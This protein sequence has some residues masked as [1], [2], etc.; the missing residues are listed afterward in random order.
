MFDSVTKTGIMERSSA[1]P[2]N[3]KGKCNDISIYRI[4]TNFMGKQLINKI[5][6]TRLTYKILAFYGTRK[7]IHTWS[8]NKVRELATLCL[9]WQQWTKTSVWFD[10]V[11]IRVSAFHRCVLLIYGSLFLSGVYY[12]MSVFWCAVA[13]MSE[14]LVKMARVEAISERC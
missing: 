12:C 4:N 13:R 9:P 1:L 6:F 5:V 3:L 11:G 2:Q 10:D 8:D 14:L 7:F